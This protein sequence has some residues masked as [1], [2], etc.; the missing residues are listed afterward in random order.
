MSA[1]AWMIPCPS[2]PVSCKLPLLGFRLISSAKT[3]QPLFSLLFA[4]TAIANQSYGIIPNCGLFQCCSPSKGSS[5]TSSTRHV[6]FVWRNLRV[7][8]RGVLALFPV[9]LVSAVAGQDAS[10]TSLTVSA[11]QAVGAMLLLGILLNF[12]NVPLAIFSSSK[13]W[14]TKFAL[15]SIILST[16]SGPYSTAFC[17][18]NCGH[19]PSYPVSRRFC[20]FDSVVLLVGHVYHVRCPWWLRRRQPWCGL[21]YTCCCLVPCWPVFRPVR[22]RKLI[23]RSVPQIALPFRS[24]CF[25]AW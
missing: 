6:M 25:P 24:L 21:H 14:A 12:I 23:R 5:C 15:V 7:V 19:I 9:V 17:G 3:L 11:S 4:I 18:G 20:G 1:V 2:V 16:L 8:S 13:R 10:Y 22:P